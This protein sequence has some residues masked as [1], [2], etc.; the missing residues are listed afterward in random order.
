MSKTANK[1]NTKSTSPSKPKYPSPTPEFEKACVIL[2]GFGKRD[3]VR[4]CGQGVMGLGVLDPIDGWANGFDDC[5][6]RFEK[7][8]FKDG[9]IHPRYI[10]AA[11]SMTDAGVSSAQPTTIALA[12]CM[13]AGVVAFMEN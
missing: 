9:K 2:M 13:M 10:K 7:A 4:Q 1:S 3:I 12:I 8:L 5:Y 11:M 6:S